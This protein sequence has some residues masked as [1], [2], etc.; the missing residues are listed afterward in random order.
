MGDLFDSFELHSACFARFFREFTSPVQDHKTAAPFGDKKYLNALQKI[1]NSESTQLSIDVDDVIDFFPNTDDQ[2]DKSFGILNGVIANTKRYLHIIYDAADTVKAECTPPQVGAKLVSSRSAAGMEQANVPI[3]IR[4]PF[5]VNIRPSHTAPVYSARQIKAAH[6][7]CL[8]KLD[9]IV[10]KV[11]AVKP[12]IKVAAYRCNECGAGLFQS[13][14]SGSYL[15]LTECSSASCMRSKA[16]GDLQFQIKESKVVKYQEV[17]VQEPSHYVPPGTIPRS[18]K[19]IAEG[20]RTRILSPGVACTLGG[21]VLPVAKTGFLALTAGLVT[22]TYFEVHDVS[23]HK[24]GYSDEASLDS[25]EAAYYAEQ[26]EGCDDLYER[27]A[28]SIAPS[29]CGHE[30]VKKAVLLQLVGGSSK[31]FSDLM[32]I[33]G[34]IHVL[35]MGDPGV[36]KSQILRQVCTIAPRAHYTTGKGAS[37]VGLTAA[38]TKDPITGEFALEGGAIVLADNG[39]CCIDEFDKMEESDRTA[40][41]EVMEQQTVS[42]AKAGLTTTLNARTSVLAAANPVFGRYDIR[43]SPVV[44]MNLPAALLSRFDILFLILDRADLD[45]DIELARYVLNVHRHGSAPTDSGAK[46]L[47]FFDA[48]A[49][50]MFIARSRRYDPILPEDLMPEIIEHY[51]SLRGKERQDR[52]RDAVKTVTTPRTLLGI[53]RLSQALAR[54]RRSQEIGRGDFEEAVRLTQCST[55]SVLRQEHDDGAAGHTRAKVHDYR[56]GIMDIVK[57]LDSRLGGRRE[58]DGWLNMA[59]DLQTRVQHAGYT[60]NQLSSTLEEYVELDVLVWSGAD[61]SGIAFTDRLASL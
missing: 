58:W 16:R 36:A 8:V 56:T 1:S 12:R 28:A 44:N 21:V 50:R 18:L 22:D 19:V 52:E 3:S 46:K 34:D 14:E 27:L 59:T 9:C 26:F 55:D 51:V 33:R 54:L 4:A 23:V 17:T 7:G 15:P 31:S 37:G 47:K 25:S 6:V 35:L 38:V 32:R 11:T 39:V 43:K 10:V 42:V 13:V 5:E 45:K 57:E 20:E 40:I 48:K 60:S 41:H 24:K 49:M 61:K 2:S 29:I 30:D 53:L